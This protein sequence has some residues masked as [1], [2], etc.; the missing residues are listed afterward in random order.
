MWPVDK[1]VGNVRNDSPDLLDPIG[2]A[3]TLAR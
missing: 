1:R 3:L 2:D